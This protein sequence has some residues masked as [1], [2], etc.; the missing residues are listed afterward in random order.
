MTTAA[1]VKTAQFGIIGLGVMGANLALNVEEHG[2]A[3]AVWNLET[4]WVD[5]FLAQHAGRQFIG[6]HSLQEFC[7]ALERPRRILMMIQAGDP[8]DQT[9]QKLTPYLAPGDIVIDGGN[10]YF[11][12]T[13]RRELHSRQTMVS[14][15]GMGVSGGE[16]GARHGPSLMPGGARA[17]Y[18]NVP[19]ILESI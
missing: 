12:D 8:V 17:A 10:S 15:F 4:E 6:A 5:R 13:M 3:V 2:R 16:D 18:E 14:F 9:L 19:P 1:G 7:R 11:K